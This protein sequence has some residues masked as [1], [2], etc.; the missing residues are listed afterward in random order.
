MHTSCIVTYIYIYMCMYICYV[1]ISCT[2]LPR[3]HVEEL[4]EAL[5]PA[6][7]DQPLAEEQPGVLEVMPLYYATLYYIL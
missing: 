1:C 6:L 3:R 5:D 2:G 4:V 7:R